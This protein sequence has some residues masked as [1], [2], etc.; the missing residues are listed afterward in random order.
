MPLQARVDVS[1]T[2][3]RR[4]K[5]KYFSTPP[6]TGS[7]RAMPSNSGRDF[8]S[9]VSYS[10]EP[11]FHDKLLSRRFQTSISTDDH[12]AKKREN[13]GRKGE[14]MAERLSCVRKRTKP[15]SAG[16]SRPRM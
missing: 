10:N 2:G 11:H 3:M 15:T 13:K 6:L 14:S 4:R 1:S 12:S 5:G 9:S 16:A 7:R 8:S